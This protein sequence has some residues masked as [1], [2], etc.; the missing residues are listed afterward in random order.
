MTVK[1]TG[2]DLLMQVCR[3]ISVSHRWVCVWGI[4]QGSWEWWLTPCMTSPHNVCFVWAEQSEVFAMHSPP[5]CGSAE[6]IL[7][8][9]FSSPLSV[10]LC[11]PA[12]PLFHSHRHLL[13]SCLP[14]PSVQE[15]TGS[16]SI[17]VFLCVGNCYREGWRCPDKNICLQ[18]SIG[19]G[20]IFLP[21]SAILR[22][23]L[24]PE[25]RY[26]ICSPIAGSVGGLERPFWWGHSNMSV[27]CST[28]PSAWFGMLHFPW[29]V[30]LKTRWVERFKG[31]KSVVPPLTG[32]KVTPF[33]QI[34]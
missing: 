19:W 11:P 34:N 7:I 10:Y 20:H 1:T 2:A 12:I 8:S 9:S 22:W 30:A 5:P 25:W 4:M 27:L 3:D 21:Y 33:L 29:R 32:L 14:H 15:R 26:N 28:S 13:H 24:G 17:A 23:A 6:D 16:P 18:S 31:S